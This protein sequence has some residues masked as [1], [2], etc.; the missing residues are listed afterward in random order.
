MFSVDWF[1][2]ELSNMRLPNKTKKR[3]K[4]KEEKRGKE[5]TDVSYK[6]L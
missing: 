4:K 5:V 2:K 1:V 6:L 3:E